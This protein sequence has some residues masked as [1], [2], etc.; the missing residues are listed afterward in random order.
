MKTTLYMQTTRIS[1]EQTVAQIQR[2][3][4]MYGASAIRTDYDNGEVVSVSFLIMVDGREI[5][6]RLPCRWEVIYQ[7]IQRKRKQRAWK[8]ET[9][10]KLQAKR[11]AWR[12][13]LRWLE[14]QFALV[15]TGMVKTAEIFMPFIQVGVTETL[16]ER[17]ETSKFKLLEHK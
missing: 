4:G 1:P 14:A 10:D 12:Q 5:P 8:K 9:D 15:D 11:V 2:V 6:F 13:I 3:I 7:H 17:L 16:Y